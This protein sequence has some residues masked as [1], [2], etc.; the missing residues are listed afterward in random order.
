M[1]RTTSFTA[2]MQELSSQP[3]KRQ[4]MEEAV[5]KLVSYSNKIEKSPSP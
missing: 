5:K 2:H 4:V 3:G 1:I